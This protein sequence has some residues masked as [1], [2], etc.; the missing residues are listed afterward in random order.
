VIL[1]EFVV[2]FMFCFVRARTSGF[3]N[4][5]ELSGKFSILAKNWISFKLYLIDPKFNGDHESLVYF[6][7]SSM[8]KALS[9]T[10]GTLPE[11]LH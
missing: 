10:S 7:G 6:Y 8:V 5:P 9:L 1:V 4:Y 11:N 2:K 3:E